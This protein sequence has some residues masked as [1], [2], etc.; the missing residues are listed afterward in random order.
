MKIAIFSDLHDNLPNLK[1]FLSWCSDNAI[2]A[3]ICCGDLTNEETLNELAS[4]FMGPIYLVRG[5]A[6]IYDEDGLLGHSNIV[7]GGRKA[8]F[9]IA[10]KRIGVCHEPYL[11]KEVFA[12]GKPDIIFYGHTHKPW[13]E[14][15]DSALLIN[16]GALSG[17]YTVATFSGWDTDKGWP[18]LKILDLLNEKKS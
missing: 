7:D 2:E 15:E 11:I 18:E 10:G 1:T 8:I 16:P 17:G 6:D 9:D 12:L 5:N 4:S 14:D 13:L 3:L